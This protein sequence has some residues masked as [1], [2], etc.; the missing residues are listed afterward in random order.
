MNYGSFINSDLPTY[1]Y[2]MLHALNFLRFKFL[3]TDFLFLSKK[4][5]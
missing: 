3:N 1:K 5:N 2:A 4:C